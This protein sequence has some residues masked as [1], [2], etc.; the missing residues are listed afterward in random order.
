MRIKNY[1]EKFR[2]NP[3]KTPVLEFLFN[4]AAG[5]KVAHQ[6]PV[7]LLKKRHTISVFLWY[8]QIVSIWFLCKT[9]PYDRCW[10]LS[11]KMYQ[12]LKLLIRAY[13]TAWK[14]SVF[15]VFLVRIFPHSDWIR[16]R[17]LRIWTLFTKCS[18][19]INVMTISF[20][21]AVKAVIFPKKQLGKTLVKM[22]V[23]TKDSI[24]Y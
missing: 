18:F 15:G 11:E 17:K 3:K 8:W 21:T 20:K 16:I 7:T 13:S 23:F 6:Q 10:W 5:N 4:K 1:S 9:P 22:L 2:K 24:F 19:I 14:V 12:I